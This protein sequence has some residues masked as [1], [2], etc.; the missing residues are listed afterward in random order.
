MTIDR[1]SRSVDFA[2]LRRHLGLRALLATAAIVLASSLAAFSARPT[3]G[4]VAGALIFVLG[5]I[6]AGAVSGL[7]SGLLAAFAAFLLYNFYF[8]EPVLTL[9]LAT[10][11]DIAPLV[12]FNLCAVVAGVLA[13][14]LKDSAQAARR[15]SDHFASLLAMSQ[16]LQSAMRLQDIATILADLA[17]AR[18]GMSLQI[19][20][21]R[22][23]QVLPLDPRAE[24]GRWHD[25]AIR[26]RDGDY[27]TIHDDDL[28]VSRLTGSE[29]VAGIVVVGREGP[30]RF[31]PAFMGAL[32]GLIAFAVERATLSELIA[33][34]RAAART[35]ELKTALL[36]SVS[37]DFRTPLTAISASASSLIDYREQL[38]TGTSIRLLRGIVDECDR[39]NRYTANL[40]E[41]S[42]LEAGEVPRQLQTLGVS[43]VLAA[44]VH[45]LRRRAGARRIKRVLAGADLLVNADAALFELVLVNVI[46]NAILYS[47]DGT[48]ILI[49]S[50]EEG[51]YCRI[52]V[53]DEGA[54]IPHEDLDRVFDRF[55]RV[56]R[57]EPSPRGSGL[58]LAIARGFVE[59]LGGDIAARTPGVGERGTRI[60]IRLPLA[61]GETGA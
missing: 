37:H 36:S 38:D 28:V 39:L 4:D 50:E 22:N 47:A 13:G 16:A 9:R 34:N 54:G 40:L 27:A 25:L 35:E 48:R 8:V 57:E 19:F 6:L 45:R 59:A 23:D 46:D 20:R 10:E 31:D 55:F 15:S 21:V 52:T 43:E 44:V 26:C 61:A 41:M 18:L 51:G 58:G 53:A 17:P 33:E 49:E 12:V 2:A 32:E 14:R 56:S 29:G 60:I 7:A 42:R 30:E 1:E 3:L 24:G 5:I 11:K